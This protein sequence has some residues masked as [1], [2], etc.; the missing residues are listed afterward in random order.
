MMLSEEVIVDSKCATLGLRY[1]CAQCPIL[2]VII[3]WDHTDQILLIL[4]YLPELAVHIE[5]LCAELKFS[6]LSG[7]KEG[8]VSHSIDH[9]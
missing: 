8:Q 9:I 4:F 3:F 5:V 2:L 7:I 6:C 1:G